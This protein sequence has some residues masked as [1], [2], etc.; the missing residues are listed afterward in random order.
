MPGP[1]LLIQMNIEIYFGIC[2]KTTNISRGLASPYFSCWLWRKHTNSEGTQKV[3]R[4]IHFPKQIKLWRLSP[5][6]LTGKEEV[7]ETT[8]YSNRIQLMMESRP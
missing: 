5:S 6:R 8:V 3:R 4:K 7:H 2:F 1:R